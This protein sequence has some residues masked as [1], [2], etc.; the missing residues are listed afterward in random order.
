MAFVVR[1]P[2]GRWEIRE[3]FVGPSGP[4]ARTLASFRVLSEDVIE[5]VT[6]TTIRGRRAIVRRDEQRPARDSD[7]GPRSTARGDR[8]A[9]RGDRG[10]SRGDRGASRGG[11]RERT[12]RR[13]GDRE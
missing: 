13:R 11:D 5:R 1:R 8:G 12:P 4:R 10:A 6:G 3:S 2:K 9:S 7:R